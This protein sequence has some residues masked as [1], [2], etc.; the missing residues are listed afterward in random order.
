LRYALATFVAA[1]VLAAAPA[2]AQRGDRPAVGRA[3][4]LVGLSI[5]SSDGKRIGK[6]LATGVDEDN[7]AVLIA[8]IERPLGIGAD[9][10][11]IPFD[12]FVRKSN[13][14]ELT[15]TAAEVS[16]RISGGGRRR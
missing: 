15:I 9:A 4:S 6:I 16:A 8:E 10:V 5:F 14:V 11:A 7:H 12:M 3:G 1:V 2:A 13:R